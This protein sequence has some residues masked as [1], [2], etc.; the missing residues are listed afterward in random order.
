V[1]KAANGRASIHRRADGHGW[2]G[3][4]SLGAHP[5]TAKRWRKHVRGATKTE[6]ARK[7]TQLEQQ[8]H[9]GVVAV[10][11][12][13]T[14]TGWLEAWL[15]GRVAAGLRQN[16]I[17][18]YRTDLK[19]VARSGV[20]RVR[21]RDLSP[22]R[23]EQVYAYVIALPRA[24]VG[25]AA[26]LRRTLNAALNI[27]VQRGHLVRNPVRLAT[28]PRHDQPA[29][30]PYSTEEIARLLAAARGRRNGVHWSL[31]L[32][33][34]RQGEVLA[35]RWSDI[36]LDAGELTIRHTL[37]WLRWQHG[38]PIAEQAPTCGQPAAR[39]PHRHSGGPHLGP[40]KS[41]AGR[42][43]IS[44]PDPVIVQ[45]RDHRARQATERLA[46]GERWHEQ[47]FVITNGTGGPVDRT[48]DRDDWHRL[49][50]AAGVRRLRIHDLRHAAATALLVLGADSRTLLGVMGWTN[51][52][53]VQR[54]TH[55]VPDIRR[56]IA[57][58][59]T[60]LWA[61]AEGQA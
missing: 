19:Y 23:V 32:L 31:A 56:N 28:V 17:S 25:S 49:V 50:T 43:T 9:H 58:R 26:H 7:I 10:D 12:G 44:L 21:L 51:M 42:R 45:L 3:W 6:V 47:D 41:A 11:E 14:V 13:T 54:Y 30:Q 53:L 24:G 37:T 46:A 2:E 40:P 5:V 39:C 18:A 8:R 1:S 52:A 57:H 33:G 59:Q 61:V 16:S 55:I 4:V 22:E 20:G 34:L 48:S 29:L 38:C 35:L 60:A 15:A 27:A 36:N